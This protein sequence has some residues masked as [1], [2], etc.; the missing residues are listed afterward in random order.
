MDNINILYAPGEEPAELRLLLDE[1]FS[2]LDAAWPDKII[3]WADWDH[4]AWDRLAT[5]LCAG[6]GYPYG[7]MFLTAY[8]YSILTED[9]LITAAPVQPDAS[10]GRRGGEHA[11]PAAEYA[12]GD[13]SA[14]AAR[15]AACEA[16]AAG[17]YAAAPEEPVPSGGADYAPRVEETLMPDMAAS[18]P[19]AAQELRANEYRTGKVVR[20]LQNGNSGFI[21]DDKTGRDY[22][23][24]V[25]NFTHWVDDLRIGLAASYRIEAH[26]VRKHNSFRDNAVDLTCLHHQGVPGLNAAK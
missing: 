15:M 24:N 14:D 1:L 20:V 2:C 9:G 23:F 13:A 5:R 16:E 7:A 19:A 17:A 22:Y 6:L 25:R 8:G 3:V 10:A 11:A 12:Q 21:R 4:A 26:F 18:A